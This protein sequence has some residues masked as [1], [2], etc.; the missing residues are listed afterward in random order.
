MSDTQLS[1]LAAGIKE[2][3]LARLYAYW[4]SR[5]GNRR[6]PTRRDLD[7]VDLRYILG[8][9][10]LLDVLR[11]PLRF[12]YRLHGAE[13][14]ARVQYDLTGKFLDDIPDPDYRD[15]AVRRCEGLVASGEPLVIRR[16]RALDGRL[17]PYEALWL[18]FSED[19]VNVTMLLCALL[20]DELRSR[21]AG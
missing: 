11:D 16:E 20:Y 3:R 15:Y 6:F 10:M 8:H 4:Q 5:K 19:G 9:L 17:R 12:R 1:E 14:T 7:P 13:I 2:P 21:I 18:P